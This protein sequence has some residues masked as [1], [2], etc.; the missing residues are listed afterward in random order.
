[1]HMI[2]LK[3]TFKNVLKNVSINAKYMYCYVFYFP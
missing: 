3:D 1:M 2:S